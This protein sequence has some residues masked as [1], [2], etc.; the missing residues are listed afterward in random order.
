MSY[1]GILS[2]DREKQEP[3]NRACYMALG[4]P[5]VQNNTHRLKTQF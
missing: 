5:A 1:S 4:V 3:I 2:V